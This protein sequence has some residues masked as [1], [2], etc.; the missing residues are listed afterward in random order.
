MLADGI[1]IDGARS[2]EGEEQALQVVNAPAEA[3]Y[4]DCHTTRGLTDLKG[5]LWF[6]H[7][8]RMEGVGGLCKSGGYE[9][10]E[11]VATGTLPDLPPSQL[12]S[13]FNILKQ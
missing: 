11:H 3:S 6:K 2:D 8:T 4:L 13:R 12:D 10:L 5:M 7:L 9:S 1:G